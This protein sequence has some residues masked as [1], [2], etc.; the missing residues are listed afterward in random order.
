[1]PTPIPRPDPFND[2]QW[3]PWPQVFTDILESRLGALDSIRDAL[4]THVV[5]ERKAIERRWSELQADKTVNEEEG[6]ARAEALGDDQW[7]LDDIARRS[8]LMQCVFMYHALEREL[9]AILRWRYRAVPDPAKTDLLR[10]VHRWRFLHEDTRRH[11]GFDLRAVRRYATVNRLRCMANSVKHNDGEVNDELARAA[12]WKIGTPIE[13]GRLR[14]TDLNTAC[15][16]FLGHFTQKAERGLR[17]LL[18][19]PGP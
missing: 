10:R 6:Q 19:K 1:M 8:S 18:G 13:T 3:L 15:L 11:L 2:R 12:R 7:G 17:R 9:W 14:F 16:A 4:D 5:K